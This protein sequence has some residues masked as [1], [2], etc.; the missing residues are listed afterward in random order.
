MVD[1]PQ[2]NEP[3]LKHGEYSSI[4]SLELPVKIRNAMQTL[5]SWACTLPEERVRRET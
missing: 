2:T 5:L 1:N 3:H 4:F